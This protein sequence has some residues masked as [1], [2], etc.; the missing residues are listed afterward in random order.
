MCIRDSSDSAPPTKRQKVTVLA[1]TQL[2]LAYSSKDKHLENCCKV[3]VEFYLSTLSLSDAWPPLKTVQ[4]VELALVRQ[5]NDY[6]HL[7][8]KTI[9]RDVDQVYGHKTKISFPELL[10]NVDH[11][12]VF[13]FEGRPGCGKTTLMLKISHD[14]ARGEILQSKLVILVQLRRLSGRADIYINDLLQAACNNLS[15]KDAQFLSA[16]FE[17]SCGEGVVFILDG[18][19][20]YAPGASEQNFIYKLIMLSLIHI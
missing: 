16:H 17:R 15:T 10:A 8:L 11:K 5:S 20:E 4:F 7:G 2:N 14:W 19:D 12:S 1:Q 6:R 3:L 13:L 9:S 18:F